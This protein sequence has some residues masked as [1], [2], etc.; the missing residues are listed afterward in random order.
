MRLI[1]A[2]LAVKRIEELTDK[3]GCLENNFS[4][5]WII[6]FLES[7]PETEAEPIL[8]TAAK[9]DDYRMCFRIEEAKQNAIEAEDRK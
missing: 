5:Q 1:D 9:S 3:T 4:A 7:F 2:E 6:D 8:Q